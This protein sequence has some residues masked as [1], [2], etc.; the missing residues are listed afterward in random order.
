[1]SLEELWRLFPVVL[2]DNDPG[3][4]HWYDDEARRLH[5]LLGDRVVR[6]SHIGSTAVPGLRAK[7]TVDLL[8]ETEALGDSER[9]AGELRAAGWTVMSAQRDPF[10]QISLNKGYAP[11]GFADKV[12]HL[13]V[14]QPG[15]W[16]EPY[17]RDYLID[18][19]DVAAEYATLKTVLAAR[20]TYDR[21]A[22]TTAKADFV[23]RVTRLARQ[24]YS[25]RYR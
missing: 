18:H 5:R 14:R 22:Y 4:R 9:L 10:P 13:H 15:D 8:L 3:Y 16:G 7:P 25:G 21:D 17:F 23:T 6:L 12:F 24:A 1:M 11:D 20:F 2:R 19:S